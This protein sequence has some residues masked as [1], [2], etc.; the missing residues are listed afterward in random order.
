[1]TS[2]E[3]DD[4]VDGP[5]ADPLVSV[6][7]DQTASD[8]PFRSWCQLALTCGLLFEFEVSRLKPSF[9]FVFQPSLHFGVIVN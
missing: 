6:A 7:S 1:M 4:N 5:R 8:S 9:H 2:V 3:R